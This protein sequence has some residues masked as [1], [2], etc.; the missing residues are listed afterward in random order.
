MLEE[1]RHRRRDR[2]GHLPSVTLSVLPQPNLGRLTLPAPIHQLG[3][4]L[5]S[6]GDVGRSF[7]LVVEQEAVL[8][9]GF[10]K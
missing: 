1:G 2:L 9:F 8:G 6:V 10:G 4:K 3:S 5:E 7:E